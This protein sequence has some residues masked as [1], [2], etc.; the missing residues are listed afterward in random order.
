[1]NA[2]F[3][4]NEQAGDGK[5]ADVWRNL[6]ADSSYPFKKT[7]YKGHA[8]QLARQAV[9]ETDQPVLLVVIGGDGTIHEVLNGIIGFE[10]VTI[11]VMKAGSGNDFAREFPVFQDFSEIKAYL[12]TIP[13]ARKAADAGVVQITNN[14]YRHF[15]SNCGF[16]LDADISLS[17][18][19]SRIKK[20]LNKWKLGRLVYALT[21]AGC[22][23]RFKRFRASV[24]IGEKT[25]YFENVWMLTVSNQKYYGGGMKISPH[26]ISDD[27]IFELTVVHDI[28]LLKFL[29]VFLTVF[30]GSHTRF[31]G[32]S[33]YK[34]QK[35]IFGVDQEIGCHCDGEYIGTVTVGQEVVCEVD[36]R[37]WYVSTINSQG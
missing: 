21:V 23:L 29:A 27:G 35:F 3:I 34:S 22:L 28:S 4:I 15:A 9:Q 11:G 20:T 31:K 6:H 1:M 24:Q 33:T 12:N 30:N 32:V 16:G 18:S 19:Q 2:V 10:H 5:G 17:V 13:I 26:S 36:E 25:T 7:A 14:T 8:T 37:K